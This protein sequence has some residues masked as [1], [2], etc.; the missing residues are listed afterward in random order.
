MTGTNT[1]LFFN[2]DCREAMQ[3]Y[4]ECFGGE[5]FLMT[6][7][8]APE[9]GMKI[10]AEAKGRVMHAGLKVGSTMLMASDVLPGMPFQQG[11]NFNVNVDC[12]TPEEVDRL[13]AALGKGGKITMPAAETFWAKRFGGLIDRFGIGWMLNKMKPMQM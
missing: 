7:G 9:S 3:F 10:P 5:L 2:G 8:E 11:T 6:Y 4:K 1:Y 13:L 12:E